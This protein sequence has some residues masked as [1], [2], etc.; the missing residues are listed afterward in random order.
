M[1]SARALRV[2]VATLAG[3]AYSVLL[4]R[5]LP[6]TYDEARNWL[7]FS[8]RGVHYVTH[9]YLVANNH[10]LYT[11]LIS[12]LPAAD[13]RADPLNLRLL[14]I[15]VAIVLVDLMF[16]WLVREGVPWLVGIAALLLSGPVT[17][18][19]FGVARGYLLGTLLTFLGIQLLA[20]RRHRTPASIGAGVLFALAIYTVP[21]FALGMV[22]IG[23]LLLWQRRLVD[24]VLW[25]ATA[26][27]IAVLLYLPILHQVLRAGQGHPLAGGHR[28]YAGRYA[29]GEYTFTVLRDSFYL[30]AFGSNAL[31]VVIAAV[32]VAGLVVAAARMDGTRAFLAGCLRP[33]RDTTS[34]FALLAVYSAGALVVI[35][36]ANGTRITSSPFVRNSLFVGYAAMLL[37]LRELRRGNTDRRRRVAA[38]LIGANLVASA[39]GVSLLVS[40]HDYSTAR[41]GDILLATP[42]SELRDVSDLGATMVVCSH[43]DMQVCGIYRPYLAHRGIRVRET[44][45]TTNR[46]P[47]ETGSTLPIEGHGVLV[48]RGRKALGLLCEG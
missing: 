19:Y 31:W 7:A 37:L 22:G 29:P 27:V 42:P 15:V 36:L 32:V 12:F 45:W 40:G 25:G 18:I 2:F 20:V 35:E 43:K 23:I 13:V 48:R 3:A 10:V 41:Y 47:C 8:S 5:T 1:S 21:T 38:A 30:T 4:S 44:V 46:H 34:V 16:V 28:I 17:V 11:S 6:L 24:T 9:N 33:A 39:I 14:N 26:V